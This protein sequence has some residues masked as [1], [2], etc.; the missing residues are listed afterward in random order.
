M[1]R[2]F[3]RGRAWYVDYTDL[4][5]R[6]V[7]KRTNAATKTDAKR[8]LCAHLDRMAKELQEVVGKFNTADSRS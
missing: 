7:K 6:R 1:A 3:R 2:V 5:G 8:I 4:N